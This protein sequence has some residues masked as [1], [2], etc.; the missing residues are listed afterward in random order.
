MSEPE[1][2]KNILFVDDEKKVLDGLRRMLHGMRNEWEMTFV[3]SGKEALDT[4]AQ[5]AI[6][7]IVSDMRMPEM[8]GAELL[9]AVKDKYPNVIRFILS[10]YSDKEMILKTIES[11]D[12]FLSKPCDPT[13]LKSAIDKALEAHKLVDKGK[14]AA[15]FSDLRELP[16]L[17]DLYIKLQKLLRDPESSFKRISDLIAMD[18]AISARVLQLVNSSFFGLVQRIENIQHAVTY[19]GAETLKSLILTTNVFSQFKKHELERYYIKDLYKH[20]IF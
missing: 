10:G 9:T 19:L 7:V 16:T 12:Q 17:P 11:T 15:M 13:K 3:N 5:K 6:D 8:G 1:K 14:M 20:C 2:K 18:I 4:L